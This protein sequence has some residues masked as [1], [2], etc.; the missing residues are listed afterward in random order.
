MDIILG[1]GTFN[2]TEMDVDVNGKQCQTILLNF[3]I[4][5]AGQGMGQTIIH[6]MIK[7]EGDPSSKK[8]VVLRDLSVSGSSEFGIKSVGGMPIKMERCEVYDCKDAGIWLEKCGT[9]ALP[10]ELMDCSVHHNR[11]G[12]ATRQMTGLLYNMKCQNNNYGIMV[13]TNCLVHVRGKRSMYATNSEMNIVASG[14][15]ATIAIHVLPNNPVSKRNAKGK[16]TD[17]RKGGTI[18]NATTPRSQGIL[19]QLYFNGQGVHKSYAKARYWAQVSAAQGFAESQYGLGQLYLRAEGVPQN[20]KK[21]EQ[22]FS[23]AAHQGHAPATRALA[24][25]H[26]RG[27]G[28]TQSYSKALELCQAAANMGLAPAQNDLA[29]M[30]ARG[31]GANQSWKIAQHWYELAAEQKYAAAWLNLGKM[32]FRGDGVSQSFE[33]ARHYFELAAKSNDAKASQGMYNLAAMYQ[34]GKGVG[35]SNERARALLKQ[36]GDLGHKQAIEQLAEWNRLNQCTL[37]H[38]WENMAEGK[39]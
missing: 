39:E 4:H 26:A 13:G 15:Q 16:D 18:F 31:L 3:P 32:Y 29:F 30:Y 36:A 12:I 25:M 27:H 22:W 14:K 11:V 37:K 33:R 24:L 19:G 20:Y 6:G 10:F 2:C 28:V 7:I 35:Q 23:K 9:D 38:F 34:H 1:A 21:A 8:R 5:V 17:S